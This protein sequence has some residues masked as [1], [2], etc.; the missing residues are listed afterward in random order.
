MHTVAVMSSVQHE[1]IT[2]QGQVPYR[3]DSRNIIFG[4]IKLICEDKTKKF[5]TL[6][7]SFIPHI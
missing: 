7:P 5:I 2:V 3:T 6:K 4:E 1:K